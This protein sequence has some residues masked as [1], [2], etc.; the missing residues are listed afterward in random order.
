MYKKVT[1]ILNYLIAILLLFAG[2]SLATSQSFSLDDMVDLA[3]K[4]NPQLE[5]A[6]SQI[7][8]DKG[9]LTQARSLYLPHLGAGADY[10][11]L[12][13]DDLQPV[14]E[15][16]SVH[17]LL[18]VSQLIYGFGKVTGLVD[19]SSFVVEASNENYR[20][21]ANNIV[22]QTKALFYNVLEK[23]RLI[24]VS[25]QAVTNYEQQLERAQAFFKTGV[26]TRLDVT[27]AE[28]NLSTQQLNLLRARSDLKVARINLEKVV[29]TKPADGDY[30]LISNE[31]TLETILN[32]KPAMPGDLDMLLE[33]AFDNRPG[34]KQYTS[35]VQAA[36]SSITHVRGD[37]WPTVNAY[38]NYEK[39]ETD[40]PTLVDQWYLG[41][42]LTWELFSGF[43]TEGKVA[44]A[45]ANLRKVQ[46][47][48]KDY[49]L[50]V[51]QETTDSYLRADEN[52]QAITIAAQRLELSAD[53]LDLAEVRYTTGIGNLLEFNDAQLLNIESQ[54]HMV[55]TYYN[56]LTSL[57][58]IEKSTGVSPHLDGVDITH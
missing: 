39:Y 1:V 41:V 14:E 42:G 51:I 46:A 26:R 22:Y 31:P 3:L 45:K 28:V 56:Y 20:E 6:R 29:G 12:H 35:L 49:E 10:G 37:Y 13:L 47:A 55:I 4:N 57:A 34:L 50:T 53:N 17:G 27:N 54:S 7:F 40:L 2:N 52:N 36:D 21:V 5:M 9:I 19:A 15:D 25:E 43:E 23:H 44:E 58:L 33:E 30:D 18:Q 32:E 48:L 16:N 11:R 24:T 38:G 8:A